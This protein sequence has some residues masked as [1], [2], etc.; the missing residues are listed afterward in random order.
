ME[1]R[2]TK[3]KTLEEKQ[4]KLTIDLNSARS[5][6]SMLTEMEKEYEGYSLAVKT[7]MREREIWQ[8]YEQERSE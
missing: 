4:T 2:E 7:V 6:V 3:V 8:Q 5:R 1:G